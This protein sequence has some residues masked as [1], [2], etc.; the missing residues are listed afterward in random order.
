MYARLGVRNLTTG[1]YG[2]YRSWLSPYQERA[3]CHAGLVVLKESADLRTSRTLSN[4][5]Q[6]VASDTSVNPVKHICIS[7]TAVQRYH[8][9]PMRVAWKCFLK[10]R[11]QQW[12]T[13]QQGPKAPSERFEPFAEVHA[14]WKLC[15]TVW[16]TTIN[17]SI[18]MCL[19]TRPDANEYSILSKSSTDYK[20][21]A[22]QFHE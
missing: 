22:I 7:L 16:Q 4:S 11:P 15:R 8:G 5:F 20:L 21:I 14:S 18:P 13:A 3:W 17:L 6:T 19:N 10:L 1:W 2:R 12:A 9:K